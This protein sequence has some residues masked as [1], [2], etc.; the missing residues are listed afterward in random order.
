M[1]KMPNKEEILAS[2]IENKDKI[3]MKKPNPNTEEEVDFEKLEK[4]I[5]IVKNSKN[6]KLE[7]MQRFMDGKK[8]LEA[9]KS[10]SL[11]KMWEYTY[12]P[13]YDGDKEHG[14]S[15]NNFYIIIKKLTK[16]TIYDSAIR[17]TKR[18]YKKVPPKYQGLFFELFKQL[19]NKESAI[20]KFCAC[21]PENMNFELLNDVYTFIFDLINEFKKTNTQKIYTQDK[22][23]TIP[24][25]ELHDLKY[26]TALRLLKESKD[27]ERKKE[28]IKATILAVLSNN[29]DNLIEQIR[30]I[31]FTDDEVEFLEGI[32]DDFLY[33]K[34]VEYEKEKRKL[35][36]E[37]AE[38]KKGK[39]SSFYVFYKK[40]IKDEEKN[41]SY[42]FDDYEFEVLLNNIMGGCFYTVTE[43][44]AKEIKDLYDIILFSHPEQFGKIQDDYF[45][46]ISCENRFYD[47]AEEQ[48]VEYMR[49]CKEDYPNYNKKKQEQF[50]KELDVFRSKI[51]QS[52]I[53]KQI[54]KKHGGMKKLIIKSS[55]IWLLFVLL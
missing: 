4:L 13:N 32:V 35:K 16:Y 40:I 49:K 51:Y 34:M 53:A 6:N 10:I 28:I 2:A 55:Q 12:T 27:E 26:F 54:V 30:D 24:F 37:K 38:G 39:P 29:D 1:R 3:I 47:E 5:N 7:E 18:T 21:K 20:S 44:A 45:K 46:A 23:I 43:N 9:R 52:E 41:K 19:S 11:H 50:I 8:Y 15:E 14:K 42:F 22:D 36:K 33:D 31:G 17:Q 25:F 48:I